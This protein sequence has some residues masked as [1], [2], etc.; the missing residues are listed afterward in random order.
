MKYCWFYWTAHNESHFKIVKKCALRDRGRRKLVRETWQKTSFDQDLPFCG[1]RP[2]LKKRL[3]WR[4]KTIIF[5]TT[6]CSKF[7]SMMR[8]TFRIIC[9]NPGSFFALQFGFNICVCAVS[10][11]KMFILDF[12]GLNYSDISAKNGQKFSRSGNF[13]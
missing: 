13:G 4:Q 1:N 12:I 11:R 10:S 8:V 7:S 2:R 3:E 5:L 9:L 6:F